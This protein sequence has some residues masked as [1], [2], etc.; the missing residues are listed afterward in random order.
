MKLLNNMKIGKRLG[1]SFGIVLLFLL[2]LLGVGIFSI[3]SVFGKLDYLINVN[4]VKLKAANDVSKQVMEINRQIPNIIISSS[5]AGKNEHMKKIGDARAVYVKA[6]ETLEKMEDTA[7]GKATIEKLKEALG[8][9]RNINNK[10]IE[11]GMAGSKEAGPMYEREG[12]KVYAPVEAALAAIV[13]YQEKSVQAR[14]EEASKAT[15][16]TRI[17]FI[18]VGVVAFIIAILLAVI[19]TASIRK[20]LQNVVEAADK[21]ADG[22]MNVDIQVFGKDELGVLAESFKKMT[23]TLRKFMDE[24]NSLVEQ[25][26]AGE[27]DYRMEAGQFTGSYKQMAQGLNDAVSVHVENIRKILTILVS[28]SEGDFNPVLEKLAGKGARANER[29]DQL[30]ASM[31]EVTHIAEQIA[32]GDTNI[33]VKVR[34][35]NDKLMQALAQMVKELGKMITNINAG[36]QT[37]SS[38][39]TELVAISGQMS[40]GADQTSSRSNMVATAS[41]EM[42]SNMTSVAGA[43]EQTTTNINTVATAT[44]EMT[45]T[46]G[47]IAR[48]SEKARSITGD[49]VSQANKITAQVDELGRA[50]KDIGK[51]TETISA[52]SA[53][54]NLLALNATIE[55]ARAGVAG[56]GFAVVA[57]EIKELAQQTASA[58]ED[59]KSRIDGIQATTSVAVTDIETISRVIQEV[60]DIVSGI[61]A[62]IEE[63]SAVTKDIAGNIAQAALGVK[64]VN[65]NVAQSSTVSRSIAQEIAE[66]NQAS[67][68][69]SSSSGQV[70]ISAEELS[71]LS[72]QLKELVGRYVYRA[73]TADEAESLVEKAANYLRSNG[74]EMAFREFNDLKG[75]FVKGDLYIFAIDTTGLT[76]AHGGNPKLVGNDM[77]GVKDADGKFFIQETI[78]KANQ[79]GNGW[80]DYK[81][82][83]PVTKETREKTTYFRKV[84]DVVLG[85]G[86]Y[87]Q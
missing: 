5:T 27:N 45:A 31:I 20:P 82:V 9:G 21:I 59:I 72:E 83:N 49:A 70:R 38:S 30:R 6:M 62:A 79:K 41:E 54:T 52:I 33:A 66:V 8:A 63:Q 65:H 19:I 26:K 23:M 69:I 60:N 55:A 77:M 28:Y 12:G 67:G 68:E 84:D 32:D 22:D 71:R 11:L 86:I 10:V 74:K 1:V 24:M 25:H 53:Q 78:T 16:M 36:V 48:S 80:S 51:V 17:V 46:I 37:L 76:L 57:N 73:G 40:S 61:A 81:W 64:E 34:S 85:C 50:A 29:L 47:E 43:M 7:E 15:T 14:F 18:V 56:K 2:I 35:E 75:Q 3:Q 44:E 4:S 13:S 39:S 42:S 58:T 87:K